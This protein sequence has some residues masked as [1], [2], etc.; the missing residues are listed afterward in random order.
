MRGDGS[1]V[2]PRLR[3]LRRTATPSA[4][5]T[6]ASLATI[7]AR[8]LLRL[9]LVAVL[10]I[11]VEAALGMAELE[12]LDPPGGSAAPEPHLHL[13]ATPGVAHP[14]RIGTLDRRSPGLEEGRG[15][16]KRLPHEPLRHLEGQPANS[17]GQLTTFSLGGQHT[18]GEQLS[19]LGHCRSLLSI[20]AACAQSPFG[21]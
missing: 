11:A 18:H 12:H 1:S 21:I 4:G 2:H 5:E 15:F 17:I 16:A 6:I 13:H 9:D 10:L 14:D 3:R 7:G 20:N 8:R 19:C